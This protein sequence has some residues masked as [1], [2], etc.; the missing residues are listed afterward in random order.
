MPSQSSL[1]G[2]LKYCLIYSKIYQIAQHVIIG[3]LCL[4][5]RCLHLIYLNTPDRKWHPTYSSSITNSTL[6]PSIIILA[7]LNWRNWKTEQL[8]ASSKPW[9]T[10]LR[11]MEYQWC[12]T[13]TTARA[14]LALSS[15][16][17]HWTMVSHTQLAA[18]ALRRLTAKQSAPYVQPRI[19]YASYPIHI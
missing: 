6:S 18:R 16:S 10:Y 14:I 1:Y 12:V 19:Y 15:N 13:V 3:D 2:G 4:L 5:S 11:D 8:R 9:K 17:S 7:T